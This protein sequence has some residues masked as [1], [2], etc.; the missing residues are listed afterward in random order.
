MDLHPVIPL[1]TLFRGAHLR[2]G[3][4]LLVFS[5][6]RRLDDRGIDDRA[7]LD[8]NA[9]SRQILIDDLKNLFPQPVL[10]QQMPKSA[11]GRFIWR[12]VPAQVQT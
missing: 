11:D 6:G 5:G 3:L 2:V 4:A 10:F 7:V 12:C 8:P 1:I 9:C